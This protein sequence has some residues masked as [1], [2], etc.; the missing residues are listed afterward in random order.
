[1]THLFSHTCED[2][3]SLPSYQQGYYFVICMI[4]WN[5]FSFVLISGP[6]LYYKLLHTRGP[7]AWFYKYINT[8]TNW[9]PFQ[10]SRWM[11]LLLFQK[12]AQE[13]FFSLLFSFLKFV[14][15]YCCIGGTLWHFQKCLQC[16]IVKLTPSII[17]L[18]L[19]PTLFLE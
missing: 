8:Q 10:K 1:M 12:G 4:T 3:K 18:N 2:Y 14:L 13:F 5:L 17:L 9:S 6:K 16:I 15:Y 11:L 7:N 19:P